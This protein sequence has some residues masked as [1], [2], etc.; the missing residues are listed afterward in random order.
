MI[1]VILF[2]PKYIDAFATRHSATYAQSQFEA[3]LFKQYPAFKAIAQNEPALWADAIR[4]I[5]AAM[6]AGGSD[7]DPETA[8]KVSEIFVPL[9]DRL[10][11]IGSLADD[12][13]IIKWMQAEIALVE[14]LLNENPDL[15]AG[16]L[17][18]MNISQSAPSTIT[19]NLQRQV[20]SELV[21]SYADGLKSQ[22]RAPDDGTAL[23]LKVFDGKKY[24]FSESDISV[25]QDPLSHKTDQIC[26]V[27]DKLYK[28]AATMS[29][30]DAANFMRHL[31][32]GS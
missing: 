24:H 11:K 13:H 21:A 23:M 32:N 6:Q 28:N 20:Q 25:I 3:G 7:L 14:H 30:P 10:K 31:L 2:V 27:W 29:E 18:G 17:L 15:C 9:N 26:F 16:H 22:V 5:V 12:K 4:K 1:A 8:R 19:V